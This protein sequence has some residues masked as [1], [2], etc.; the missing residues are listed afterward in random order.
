MKCCNNNSKYIL[1][2]DNNNDHDTC[3]YSLVDYMPLVTKCDIN[4]KIIAQVNNDVIQEISFKCWWEYLWNYLKRMF[5]KLLSL[6][7]D[8]TKPWKRRI[9][10][11][12]LKFINFTSSYKNQI[13][14][15]VLISAV[16]A[17]AFS[18]IFIIGGVSLLALI[19]YLPIMQI[20]KDLENYTI[21]DISHRRVLAYNK[22]TLPKLV[23]P[24]ITD[25]YSKC[26]YL[27]SLLLGKFITMPTNTFNTYEKYYIS[28]II[29]SLNLP[30]N[31]IKRKIIL[32][33]KVTNDEYF[34]Y[35]PE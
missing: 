27:R 3:S 26:E 30:K 21:I 10:V 33:S 7:I 4:I 32:V 13:Y 18:E 16:L 29:D 5:E 6:R 15:A 23:L 17:F 2:Y 28:Q 35:K 19:V 20:N 1:R 12:T 22:W 11:S 14:L 24:N 8:T 31:T 34:I 9:I 25:Y